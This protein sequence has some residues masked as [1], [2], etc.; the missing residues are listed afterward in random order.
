MKDTNIIVIQH[1]DE[2][3]LPVLECVRE[4]NLS[5]CEK[6]GFEYK[7]P[8]GDFVPKEITEKNR[9]YWQKLFYLNE[10]LK[11]DSN[12]DNWY[13][14]L[15]GDAT[16]IDFNIDLRI[17][18]YLSPPD[19]DLI[20]CN[21]YVNDMSWISWNINAGILFI[22]NSYFMRNWLSNLLDICRKT[23]GIHIDQPVLQQMLRDNYMNLADK[24][25]FF[26][27]TAFNSE[28]GNFIYHACGL[29]TCHFDDAIQQKVK[30]LSEKIKQ[31][32][33]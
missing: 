26:P 25:S 28:E 21:V 5:Y 15:D 11:E 12:L 30:I 7:T 23:N 4:N 10:L 3:Y 1:S 6:Y 14:L 22:R 27:S 19:R 32:K 8:I 29:T 9:V 16:F 24:T 31:V 13:F 18:P 33:K 17:F 2:K 20:A